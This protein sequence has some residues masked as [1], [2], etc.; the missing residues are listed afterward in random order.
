MPTQYVSAFQNVS[1]FT[2]WQTI[3]Y[4]GKNAQFACGSVSRGNVYPLSTINWYLFASHSFIRKLNDR[5]VPIIPLYT[6]TII[7]ITTLDST[8][9]KSNCTASLKLLF[10]LY[11]SIKVFIFY[12]LFRQLH[13][14]SC[15]SL[16]TI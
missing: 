9:I 2:N 13:Q 10:F 5:F 14:N 11:F 3:T 4:I 8:S 7:S 15:I 6:G 1:S 12:P 16:I